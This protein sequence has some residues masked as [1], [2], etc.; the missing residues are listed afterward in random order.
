MPLLARLVIAAA[1]LTSGWVNCFGQIEIRTSIADGLRAMNIEVQDPA[2][3][4]LTEPIP[5]EGAEAAKPEATEV[6]PPAEKNATTRGVHRIVWLIH[7]KWPDLGGW[8]T[9]IAWSAAVAQLVAGVL[10]LVGLFTRAAAFAIC[11]ATGMAVY[12]VSGGV[13]G[14]FTMN[15][16]DWPHDS[17]R[18]IQLFA[19]LG[20][21]TLSLGLLVGGAGGFS[22][23]GKQKKIA[24]EKKANSTKNSS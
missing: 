8:G 11:V 6:T 22:L 15:P 10:I 24:P 12:L 17:H 18:F 23:D 9:F 7:E 19:G 14:M 21:C 5:E 20:L 2:I 4:E 16:F 3:E 13:H 1:M